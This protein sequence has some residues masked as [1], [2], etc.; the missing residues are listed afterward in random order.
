MIFFSPRVFFLTPKDTPPL[1]YKGGWLFTSPDDRCD[2]TGGGGGVFP[3][4]VLLAGD[5]DSTDG[6]QEISIQRVRE[7][8]EEGRRGEMKSHFLYKLYYLNLKG[9]TYT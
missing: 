1:L 3:R 5:G 6:P 4:A 7:K 9:L 8:R 2:P